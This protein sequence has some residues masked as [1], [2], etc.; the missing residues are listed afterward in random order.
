MSPILG[1]AT[2][3]M[4]Y[5]R[6]Y[7]DKNLKLEYYLFS[8][9]SIPIFMAITKM[10]LTEDRVSLLS[11]ITGNKCAGGREL[12]SCRFEGRIRVQKTI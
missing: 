2:L 5:Y 10:I 3:Q 12:V 6:H 8:G 1:L 7:Y 11:R 9:Q 4:S